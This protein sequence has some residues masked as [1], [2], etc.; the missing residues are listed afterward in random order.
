APAARANLRAGPAPGDAPARRPGARGTSAVPGPQFH[1][2]QG[3]WPLCFR[4][5]PC[6]PGRRHRQAACQTPQ[7]PPHGA[8][9]VGAGTAYGDFN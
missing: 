7:P 6:S 2:I 5:S 8:C 4:C 9:Q 1:Q 3:V